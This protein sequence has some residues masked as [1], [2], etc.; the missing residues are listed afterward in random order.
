[1]FLAL[2]SVTG[3]VRPAHAS[4]CIGF[5]TVQ[6][7]IALLSVEA[8]SFTVE[9]ALFVFIFHDVSDAVLA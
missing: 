5:V 8:A 3:G 7:L 4:N 6:R 2:A 1:M 9:A